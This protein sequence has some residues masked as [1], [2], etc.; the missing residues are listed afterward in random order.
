MKFRQQLRHRIRMAAVRF[1]RLGLLRNRRFRRRASAMK[2]RLGR[3]AGP[4]GNISLGQ[5][6]TTKLVRPMKTDGRRSHRA[7]LFAPHE[8]GM[9]PTHGPERLPVAKPR[10]KTAHKLLLASLCLGVL[11]T[12]ADKKSA[13]AAFADVPA[14]TAVRITADIDA[15]FHFAQAQE[16]EQ[17]AL[18]AQIGEWI[19]TMAEQAEY[20]HWRGAEWEKH[21]IGAG[22]H[23]W[24][25]ILR[26][27]GEDIGYLVVGA[28]EDGSFVLTEYGDG[29]YP[30]FS[31]RTLHRTMRLEGWIDPNIG[32]EPFLGLLSGLAEEDGDDPIEAVSVY[33]PNRPLAAVWRVQLRG[34][35]RIVDGKTGEVYPV[36]LPDLPAPS[37]TPDR[38]AHIPS[39]RLSESL[40]SDAFDPYVQVSWM[41][42]E[43][44]D[45]AGHAIRDAVAGRRP[46]VYVAQPFGGDV[47]LPLAVIGIERWDAGSERIV[48][49]QDGPRSLALSVLRESGGFYPLSGDAGTAGQTIP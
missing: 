15:H 18:D 6:E 22:M 21:P 20:A 41:T 26:K 5:P 13:P 47:T 4:A 40:R 27:A 1:R 25:V 16:R 28:K 48:L 36:A 43:P 2:T 17:S 45:P 7:L 35:T 37:P 42:A 10:W 44:I 29:P 24:I 30:L 32:Y 49:D 11:L 9:P 31:Y 19:G 33:D 34:T 12:W 23:G 14:N 8:N 38:D 39:G 46:L 3:P